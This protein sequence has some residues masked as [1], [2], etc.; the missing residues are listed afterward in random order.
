MMF[1]LPVIV[2]ATTTFFMYTNEDIVECLS[3][4]ASLVG[5]SVLYIYIIV[6]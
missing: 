5:W 3:T 1:A 2:S 6:Y 4:N